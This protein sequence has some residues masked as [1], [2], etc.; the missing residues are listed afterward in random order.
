MCALCRP[1]AA[2]QKT[3]AGQTFCTPPFF[4]CCLESLLAG[5]T[6]I[7]ADLKDSRRVLMVLWKI[8]CTS[9]S[10][11]FTSKCLRLYLCLCCGGPEWEHI[12]GVNVWSTD[13]LLV[14]YFSSLYLWVYWSIYFL[15]M[16]LQFIQHFHISSVWFRQIWFDIIELYK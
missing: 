2:T 7:L 13:G 14:F 15:R 16:Y 6:P 11:L 4:R 8:S 1:L 3:T 9:P 10:S 12:M 5:A